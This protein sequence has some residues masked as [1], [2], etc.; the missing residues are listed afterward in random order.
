MLPPVKLTK[1][2]PEF[3]LRT[4]HGS[5]YKIR[6]ISVG[7]R[8][9]FVLALWLIPKLQVRTVRLTAKERFDSEDNA[10]KTLAQILGGGFPLKFKKHRACRDACPSWR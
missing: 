5:T 9:D 4:L 3:G 8:R 2:A 7:N 6:C 1:T 10:R